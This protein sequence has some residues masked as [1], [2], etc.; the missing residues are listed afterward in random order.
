MAMKE[1]EM[2]YEF[3][4]NGGK[5]EERMIGWTYVKGDLI[6]LRVF[7]NCRTGRDFFTGATI[8]ECVRQLEEKYG[9]LYPYSEHIIDFE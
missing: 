7:V 1:K 3:L 2:L 6:N 5:I 8:E 4:C 9:E